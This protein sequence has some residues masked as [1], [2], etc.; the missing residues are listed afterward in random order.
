MKG[1]KAKLIGD[2]GYTLITKIKKNILMA[3]S[4]KMML[5][6][7]SFVET[8]FSSMKSLNTLIHYRH[9]CPTNAFAHLFAGLIAYQI[10]DDEPT[11]ESFIKII[12]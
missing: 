7:R 6:K 11:L 8:I 10:R 9:R 12:S 2:K 5:M 3:I 1:I 4:E